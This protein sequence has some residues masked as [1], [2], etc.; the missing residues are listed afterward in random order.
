MFNMNIHSIQDFNTLLEWLR[1]ELNWDIGIDDFADM[2]DI[3]YDFD[4]KD[5]HLKPEEFATIASLKQLRPLMEN[6]PWGIFAVEFEGKRFAVS[7]LRKILA[8]LIPK[9]RNRN[10]AVWDK[11]NL[12]FFC[13]WGEKS[14]RSFGAVHFEDKGSAL[15]SIKTFY[16]APNIEDPLHL[17]SFE[18]K[19]RKLAWPS[20]PQKPSIADFK[21]WQVQWASAFTHLYQQTIRDSKLL[22]ANLANIAQEIRQRIL[23]IFSV[24][25]D[26]G[27]IHELY[28]KFRKALIHDM[29]KEQFADMYAQTIVYGLFSA[30]CMS[31][32]FYRTDQLREESSEFEPQRAIDHIPSTNPFLQN[33]LKEAFSQNTKLLFDELD[34]SEITLLLQNT[35]TGPIMEDFNRQS[36]GG[37]EDPVI[38]FYEDFLNVYEKEQK[39]RRGVYFTPMPVVQFMVRAVDD[40]LKTEFGIPQGLASTA[41]KTVNTPKKNSGD[42][43]ETK[44]VPAI[45]ILDPAV[46]TGTFLRQI[47]LQIWENFKAANKKETGNAIKRKWNGYVREHLLPRLNGFELMM[48]PYTVAHMKLALALFDTGY[49]FD[50]DQEHPDR[51]HI[52]LTNSLEEADRPGGQTML[53]EHD[54]LA[55]ESE[56]ARATKKNQGI[57]VVIGNPPYSGESAN[58]GQWILSLL[59]EYKKEP[60]GID[61]LQ[62]KN[63]KWINDDY[64]KF[65]RYAQTYVERAG[66]GIV[67][68]INN[69]SF[70]D[71]P[72]F[73]GMRWNLLHSF[74]KIYILDL[75]GNAKKKET[76]PDGSRDENVFDIQQGV[77]I[78]IFVKKNNCTTEDAELHTE[79]QGGL[80]EVFHFDLHGLREA[81]YGFL[82][83]HSMD[84]VQ[85]KELEL[86]APQFFFVQKDFGK[87]VQYDEGFQIP[88][89]LPINSVGIVSANDKLFINKSKIQLGENISNH[90]KDIKDGDLRKLIKEIHYRP[91]DTQYIYYDTEKLERPREK[92]MQHLASGNNIALVTCRQSATNDWT[93]V[94]IT[95]RIVDDSYISNRT[96]ERGYV[97]PLYRY[98]GKKRRPNLNQK[99]ITVIEQKLNLPFLP[100]APKQHPPDN[101]VPNSLPSVVKNSPAN[102]TRDYFVPIDLFDYIYAVLHCPAY[103]E[104]YREFLKIDFPRVPYPTDQE[105]F[106]N[107]VG[108]GGELRRLHLL[109]DPAFEQINTDSVFSENV[110]VEKIQYADEKVYVNRDFCF[111]DVPNTAWEFYI[112]GY[113]PAQ[114]WLKDRKGSTLTAEDLRHYRKIVLAL[115][116]TARIM[117]EID[118]VGVV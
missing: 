117:G 5:I 70:L 27:A 19:L 35:D 84:T 50:E 54:A 29:A 36:G 79:E 37:R 68:Y 118:Q 57:N 58:K 77:S 25:T 71:N 8:G 98:E 80:A 7:S 43:I 73:R 22:T 16:A 45:Q 2:D 87:Q 111:E 78:N 91:F 38:Y 26:D 31:D 83:E 95:H 9:R 39:K 17:Q 42:G 1:S 82:R 33:L 3:T 103:R 6:Q 12:L 11:E 93:L 40:I 28:E 4:A 115:T 88:E 23:D 41:T 67:A 90:F 20:L 97:F 44:S 47:V 64:V 102:S 52:F 18:A 81:K 99:I 59:D 32:R 116:E 56:A 74:D 94:G 72:T 104:T 100:E 109:E 60:G 15:P 105:I 92:V 34:L 62:E 24:E 21:G 48:A 96:K 55:E 108:L 46:G 51:V 113:Q 53:Y 86:A 89:L 66:S 106:W 85:W 114:K 65:I 75:H 101:S 61:K 30:R 110:M 49:A 13:F 63:P 10:H 107:L 112:G 76:A 69:H 14:N